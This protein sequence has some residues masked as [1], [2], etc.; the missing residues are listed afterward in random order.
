V[1][2]LAFTLLL[3]LCHQV[4]L[5]NEAINSGGRSRPRDSGWKTPLVELEG[6]TMGIVGVR[7]NRALMHSPRIRRRL[8]NSAEGKEHGRFY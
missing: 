2:Q 3:E 1:T 8:E 7:Q 4:A 5:H 6:K